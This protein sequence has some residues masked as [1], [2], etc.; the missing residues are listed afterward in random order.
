M[1]LHASAPGLMNSLCEVNRYCQ[2]PTA[3]ATTATP[4]PMR[5]VS[6]KDMLASDVEIL[7]TWSK[8]TK[9]GSPSERTPASP[10]GAPETFGEAREARAR[11]SSGHK[12]SSSMQGGRP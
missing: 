2:T 10:I 12:R 11:P 1:L 7:L 3:T 9:I 8:G 5:S 6:L 4:G